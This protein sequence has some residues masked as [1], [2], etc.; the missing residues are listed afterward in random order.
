MRLDA[1]AS[2]GKILLIIFPLDFSVFFCYI[3]IMYK[4]ML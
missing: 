1:D 3:I 4:T 2:A